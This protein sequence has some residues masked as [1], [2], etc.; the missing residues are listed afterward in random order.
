MLMPTTFDL[1]RYVYA[2]LS[3]GASGFLRKDVHR[4]TW[5]RPYGSSA[6]ATPCWHRRS[7]GAWWSGMYEAGADRASA[8]VPDGLAALTPREREVLT[9]TGRG[10]SHAE[11]AAELILSEATV[12]SHVARVFAKLG[13]RDRAQAV[14]L[15][16]ETGL[17]RPGEQPRRPGHA[18]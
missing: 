7:P 11:L 18:D 13:L 4:S 5:R 8:P 1:D 14:V 12:K 16:Y 2:A 15:A 9:M 10:L 3:I 17:V 6:P